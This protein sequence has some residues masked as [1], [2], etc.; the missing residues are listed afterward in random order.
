[1]AKKLTLGSLKQLGNADGETDRLIAADDEAAEQQFRGQRLPHHEA[2]AAPGAAPAGSPSLDAIQSAA[3]LAQAIPAEALSGAQQAAATSASE[4]PA[5]I[6]DAPAKPEDEEKDKE[7]DALAA[8]QTIDQLAALCQ[9]SKGE[10]APDAV[11]LGTVPPAPSAFKTAVKAVQAAPAKTSTAEK[12]D[13]MS[14]VLRG[15]PEAAPSAP[16]AGAKSLSLGLG[17][18][19]AT[20]PVGAS[21][22]TAAQAAQA[23]IQAEDAEPTKTARG[24]A[25]AGTPVAGPAGAA[26]GGALVDLAGR[27]IASPFLALSSAMRHLKQTGRQVGLD[28]DKNAPAPAPTPEPLSVSQASA[29]Y[30]SGKFITDWKCGRIEAGQRIVKETADRLR[31]T[32]D[33]AVWEDKLQSLVHARRVPVEQAVREMSRDTSDPELLALREGMTDL[34]RRHPSLVGEYQEAC[35]VFANH[36]KNITKDYAGSTEDIRQ[37]VSAAITNV[38]D[39][40]VNLPGFGEDLGEYTRTMAERMREQLELMLQLLQRLLGKVGLSHAGSELT[41]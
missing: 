7:Q 3:D 41:P 31:A 4:T 15:A 40:T 5:A 34:W 37:R 6:A 22:A 23:A 36:I 10:V 26:V 25:M 17:R 19:S 30:S 24:Q 21:A 16:V 14:R 1:M 39:D 8:V 38:V 28:L 20:P 18:G 33:F 2:D 27:A 12:L 29:L 35:G 13:S 32:D 9:L 11:Q